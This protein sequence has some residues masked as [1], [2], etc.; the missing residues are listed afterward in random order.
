MQH[1][2][3]ADTASSALQPS[4]MYCPVREEGSLPV[5]HEQLRWSWGRV[6]GLVVAAACAAAGAVIAVRDHRLLPGKT[7]AAEA[8]MEFGECAVVT[9]TAYVYTEPVNSFIENVATADECCQKCQRSHHHPCK[10]WIWVDN[11]KRCY[12][13]SG[14]PVQRVVKQGYVS[15]MSTLAP[16]TN[17]APTTSTRPPTP[18]LPSTSST[19]ATAA[20]VPSM[21]TTPMAT[22]APVP[23]TPATPM[24]PPVVTPT[25]A[26]PAPL[27]VP[28]APQ[29]GF[30]GA[31]SNGSSI[32]GGQKVKDAFAGFL[33]LWRDSYQ[34]NDG[35]VPE[36]DDSSLPSAFSGIK[37]KIVVSSGGAAG[38]VVTEGMGYGIMVE[39]FKAASG[40]SE[41]MTNGLGLLRSWLG[42]VNGPDKYPH[43]FGGGNGKS[44]EAATAVDKFPYGVSAIK[45]PRGGYSGVASWRFPIDQ[46]R[47]PCQGSATDGDED[48]ILGTIYLSSAQGN[49]ADFVDLVVRSIISFASADLGFPDLYRTLP[50]GQRMFVPKGGSLW[51][52]L[53][54]TEGPFKGVQEPWCY[55]PSYFAPGHYR[56]FR[57]YVHKYWRR[58]FDPYLPKH[59]DG[60]PSTLQEMVA[61]FDGAITAGY[62]LLYYSSCSSGAVGNWVGVKTECEDKEA[63][64]CE[65]VPWATTPYVGK[66]GTCSAS[67][68]TFGSYGPDAC[69]TPWRIA[70]DYILHPGDS[71]RVTIYDRQGKVDSSVVYNAKTYLNGMAN[72]Y[73]D[74]A[75][76]NAVKGDCAAVGTTKTATFKLA[77]AFDQGPHMTC[78]NVPNFAQSW[79]A[80]FMAWPTFTAF[81]AP[82][83]SMTPADN[84]KWL[85][86]FAS[87]CDFSGGKPTGDICAASYFELGQEVVATMVMSGAVVPLANVPWTPTSTPSQATGTTTRSA[88]TTPPLAFARCFG[89]GLFSAMLRTV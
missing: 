15:G 85:D 48:A 42:M 79:L 89:L 84:S 30:S 73:K 81:V 68:T 24:V 45:G 3:V 28:P 65:G 58:E 16:E 5:Q 55:N 57:D 17:P 51:G 29:P 44:A 37:T 7:S 32:Q 59:L 23:N 14:R 74:N 41:A 53:L 9:D 12:T 11:L 2:P 77:V 40:D 31:A 33:S 13:N 82:L 63:L 36:V 39:G 83:D 18:T 1:K 75:Q 76:C 43:P 86:T 49:P 50:D 69:R 6:A 52:G 27:P 71:T 19:F 46:C 61:A 67:G 25:P 88:A 20:P 34:D 21:I 87:I 38:G 66:S 64:N 47:P 72:Q 62:N 8:L 70:M 4:G 80:A 56:V 60:K 54:P 35:S 78:A 26:A 22:A 10:S